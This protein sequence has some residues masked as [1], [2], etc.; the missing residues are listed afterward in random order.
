MA[1]LIHI[2]TIAGL[3]LLPF[4]EIQASIPYGLFVAQLPWYVVFPVAVSTNI[5][6]SPITYFVVRRAIH[7]ACLIPRF[8]TFYHDRIQK[9]QKQ[10]HPYV[11]KYGIPGIAVFMASP[12]PGNGVYSTTL[13][14]HALGM[15]FKRYMIAIVCGVFLS[16]TILTAAL[17]TG[18]GIFGLFF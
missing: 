12:L 14:A 3:T 5:V 10:I 9:V 15:E 4:L 7:L 13:A 8:G 1:E 6:I 2:L 11:K 17:L 18:K 16:A